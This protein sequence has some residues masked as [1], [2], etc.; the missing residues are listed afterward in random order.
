M[1]LCADS[2]RTVRP[3]PYLLLSTVDGGSDPTQPFQSADF[4][5]PGSILMQVY[6]ETRRIGDLMTTVADKL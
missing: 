2:K 3:L 5:R 1:A 4:L 6:L